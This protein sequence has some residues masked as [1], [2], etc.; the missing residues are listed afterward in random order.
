MPVAQPNRKAQITIAPVDASAFFHRPAVRATVRGLSVVIGI[1]VSAVAF[2]FVGFVAAFSGCLGE[3]T[4]GLCASAPFLVPIL[5]WPIFAA[6]VL[7]PLTGGIAACRLRRMRWLALG[8]GVAV[9]MFLLMLALSTG[10]TG[11]LN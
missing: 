2:V 9:L 1:A 10:Q 5:E 6:A 11:V 3:E 4:A 8:A 7:G